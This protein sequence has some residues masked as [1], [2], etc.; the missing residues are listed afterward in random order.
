[1]AE[2]TRSTAYL[3]GRLWA[4]VH[5]LRVLGGRPDPGKLAGGGGLYDA[6]R[7][8]ERELNR[9]LGRLGDRLRAAHARGPEH[10]G[11]AAAV[12]RSVPDHVPPGGRL[13]P[14]LGKDAQQEFLLG[15]REGLDLYETEH[16][17]LLR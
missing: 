1:M 13:P 17:D 12:F 2:S 11:A 4:A 10:A 15:F 14:G 3:C 6:Q 5:A 7:F 16:G 8:P 9:Q